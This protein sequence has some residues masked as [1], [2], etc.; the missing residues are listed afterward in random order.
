LAGK[1]AVIVD[2]IDQARVLVEGPEVKRQQLLLKRVQLTDLLLTIPRAVGSVSLK[3]A[4]EK[5]ELV[6][7]WAESAWGKKAA[8]R[9][10]RA[11]LSDFDRFKLTSAK[12]QVCFRISLLMR[13]HCYHY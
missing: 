1:Y 5:Q 13:S 11:A 3:K 9:N 10:K 12:K 6:K 7:K 2:I 8:I 4:W